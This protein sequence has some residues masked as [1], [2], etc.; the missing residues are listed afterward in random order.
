[1]KALVTATNDTGN[2][3]L[4]TVSATIFVCRQTRGLPDHPSMENDV[5]E[6]VTLRLVK[7]H[8]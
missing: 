2:S 6:G 8:F 7:Q 3:S 1:V 5:L 4:P